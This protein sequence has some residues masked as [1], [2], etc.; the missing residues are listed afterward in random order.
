MN[1]NRTFHVTHRVNAVEQTVVVE[2][3]DADEAQE[4]FIDHCERVSKVHGVILRI[5]AA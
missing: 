5:R 4:R 2:A 1:T 3:S